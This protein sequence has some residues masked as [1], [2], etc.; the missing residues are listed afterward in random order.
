VENPRHDLGTDLFVQ[1]RDRRRYD[2]GLLV[3]VQVKSGPTYFSR[4]EPSAAEEQPDGW[5]YAEDDKRHFDY[6]A[7]HR[8]P[9]LL[10]L[11][12]DTDDM[13][14]WVHVTSDAVVDTGLGAKIL[15]P[16]TA[17]LDDQH[18]DDL[19]AVAATAL[20]G[21][22]LE[23]TAWTGAEPP[24]S[25]DVL[26]FAMVVPRLV[27]PHP[28]AA[29]EEPFTP[30]QAVALMMQARFSDLRKDAERFPGLTPTLAQ[31][32]THAE[33][34]WRFAGALAKRILDEDDDLLR[35]AL[36]SAPDPPSRAAAAVALASFAIEHGRPQD[37]LAT[38]Q[39]ALADDEMYPLDDAWLKSERARASLEAGGVEDARV[40]AGELLAANVGAPDDVTATALRGVAAIL[41]FDTAPWAER[42]IGAA[43]QATDTAAAWW[44]IQTASR[45]V[46][47]VVQR[48][49]NAWA[50]NA[51]V[52]LGGQD[53]ANNL[54]Y[55]AALTASHL[56]DHPAWRHLSALLGRDTLLRLNRHA[57]AGEAAAGLRTL[58]L[59]GAP[60]GV[61]L[62]IRQ[63]ADDGP[64]LAVREAGAEIRLDPRLARRS[65]AT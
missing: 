36:E 23:G 47:A 29:R 16:R 21:V 9:H 25:R 48:E 4:P 44:R 28:N 42:D 40:Q 62:A 17:T 18:F 57:A 59:A 30:A 49:F 56:G 5:W 15:V 13:A 43:I 41:L 54:L 34:P 19:L 14:Y 58:R 38:L 46:T 20:P 32:R 50:R 24:T 12:D 37:A 7:S 51:L 35:G 6:W 60:D 8:V 31:A 33:W 2:L 39:G 45:G 63:L 22:A 10:V 64:A 1:V 52:T 55:V 27:A 53:E 61:K 3:G 65:S 26:R 11:H